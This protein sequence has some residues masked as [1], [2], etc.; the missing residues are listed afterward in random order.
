VVAG[1]D[2]HEHDRVEVQRDQAVGGLDLAPAAAALDVLA[3]VLVGLLRE[4]QRDRLAPGEADLDAARVVV[5]RPLVRSLGRLHELG[6]DAALRGRVQERHLA[7]PDP[8]PGPLVDQAQ[9]TRPALLERL[10]DVGAA[11]GGVM[12]PRAALGDEAPDRRLVPERPQQL[13]VGLAD[14]EQSRLDALL[15]DRLA[16]LEGHPET[17]GIELDRRVEVL[18]GDA[19]VIDCLEHG[20][21]V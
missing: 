1:V 8:A 17:L 12:E 19:Y 16:V 6:Q 7:L 13:D 9:A 14:A 2:L 5:A 15:L 11:V 3:K 18:D 20:E 4:P 10:G 21:A